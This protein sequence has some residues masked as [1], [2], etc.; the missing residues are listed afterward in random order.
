[1]PTTLSSSKQMIFQVV[2][3]QIIEARADD[4]TLVN[5]IGTNGQLHSPLAEVSEWTLIIA[6]Y[7][8]SCSNQIMR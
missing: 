5:G 2:S 3:S 8:V 1:M 4:R 7:R 6:P